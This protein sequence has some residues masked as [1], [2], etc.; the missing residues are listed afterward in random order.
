[1]FVCIPANRDIRKNNR[2]YFCLTHLPA[3]ASG[4]LKFAYSSMFFLTLTAPS[5]WKIRK[6]FRTALLFIENEINKRDFLNQD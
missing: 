5:P 3:V 2:S 1:M 4:F 6:S